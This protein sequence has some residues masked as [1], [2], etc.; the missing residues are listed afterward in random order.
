MAVV[1]QHPIEVENIFEKC[2]YRCHLECSTFVQSCLNFN[3]VI[4][5]WNVFNFYSCTVEYPIT[6]MGVFIATHISVKAGG[7]GTHEEFNV[8]AKH[9]I[10]IAQYAAAR[11]VVRKNL[12]VNSVREGFTLT[13]FTRLNS[14][15]FSPGYVNGHEHEDVIITQR[16]CLEDLKKLKEQHRPPPPYSGERA[17]TPPLM[18]TV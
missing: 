8:Y 13:R 2:V 10:K 1:I 16:E 17:A 3:G 12:H 7:G 18:P 6:I 4:L 11:D 15:P 14:D 9:A 5:Y